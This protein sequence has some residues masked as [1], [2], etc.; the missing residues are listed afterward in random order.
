MGQMNVAHNASTNEDILNTTEVRVLELVDNVDVVEFDIEVLIHALERT[1][2]LNVVLKLDRHLMVYQG[3][4]EAAKKNWGG[5]V[6]VL[7]RYFIPGQK[8][9][10]QKG[11]GIKGKERVRWGILWLSLLINPRPTL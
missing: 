2:D 9:E 7:V 8:F 11:R 10:G 5:R 4:E 1:P 6:G 3:L